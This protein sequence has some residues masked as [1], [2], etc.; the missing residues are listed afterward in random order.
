MRSIRLSWQLK[1]ILGMERL[2]LPLWRWA[3]GRRLKKGKETQSSHDQKLMLHLPAPQRALP[4]G[5]PVI[6]GHAVGVGE[7]L[8]LLGLFRR[9]SEHFPAHHFLLTS[10]SRTSGEALARQQLPAHF[11]H[12]FAPVDQPEVFARFLDAWQPQLACWSETDLWPGMVVATRERGIPMFLFNAR[13]SAE[14]TKRIRK[15]GWFYQPLLRCFERIYAQNLQSQEHLLAINLGTLLARVTGNIKALAP[16]LRFEPQSLEACQIMWQ[17]R[18]IWLLAS[19]HAGEEEMVFQAHLLLRQTRMDALLI[20]VPRDAFRGG[21]IAALSRE[22]GFESS[23]RSR[24]DG[25][26]AACD[27]YIADTM[28]ELGLWYALSPVALIGGSLVP[29]G[30][31]NPYEAVAARCR[32]LSGNMTHNFSESYEELQASDLAQ[33]VSDAPSICQ[34][35]QALWQM[36]RLPSHAHSSAAQ[37]FDDILHAMSSR[38]NASMR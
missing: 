12:Q 14:K 4:Q 20:I 1:L 34:A 35:V 28:G 21:E 38:L 13:L 31:H 18:P 2:A 3:L 5:T 26:E 19:S 36:Q 24:S 27:V 23:M 22:K 37:L 15:L 25:N 6:W 16:A 32:V 33:T 29:I 10:A 8:A 30:G 7:V 17:Q 11:H 9:L